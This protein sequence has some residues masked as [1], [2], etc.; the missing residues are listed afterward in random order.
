M[1]IFIREDLT[2]PQR[3]VQASHAAHEAGHDYGKADG[4]THIVLL[5][6]PTQDALLKAAEHLEKNDIP[7]KMFFEPDYDTGYTAIATKPL[8]GDERRPLRKFRTLGA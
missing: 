4:S 6:T 2:G 3:I 5:G 7:F 8:R 1:Y